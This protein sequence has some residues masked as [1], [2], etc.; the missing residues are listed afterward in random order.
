MRWVSPTRCGTATWVSCAAALKQPGLAAPL[1][2][3]QGQ[4]ASGLTRMRCRAGCSVRPIRT[5]TSA[6]GSRR[7]TSKA[8]GSIAPRCRDGSQSSSPLEKGICRGPGWK[9][10][11]RALGCRSIIAHPRSTAL[12]SVENLQIT[13]RESFLPLRRGRAARARRRVVRAR[14]RSPVHA[15]GG[16]RRGVKTAAGARDSEALW[17]LRA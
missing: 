4:R 12:Q 11:P 6:R 5:A 16:R 14:R 3:Q 9:R 15:A 17:G 2:P 10:G 1:E 13:F 7:I 8:S